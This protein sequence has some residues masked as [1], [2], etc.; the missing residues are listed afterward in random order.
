M[1]PSEILKQ[2]KRIE[3][4]ATYL[5][6]SMFGGEYLSA[7]KGQGLEFSEVRQYAPGD[8]IR[9]ID[10]NVTARTGIPFVKV[11]HEER[12]LSVVFAVDISSS[13]RY[14]TGEKLKSEIAA[15]I[16]AV[17]AFSALKNND[18]IGLLLFS[19][20]VELYIPL[21]KG[22]KHVLR[23][24]R[25]VL[26]F[27]PKKNQTNLRLGL[28]VLHKIL[29]HK[30]VI[31]IISDFYDH[32]YDL[33]LK[34]LARSNDVIAI[35]LYDPSEREIP[36][37]G[38]VT[39]EDA[40]TGTIRHV[41]TASKLIRDETKKKYSLLQDKKNLFFQSQGIDKIDIDVTASYVGPI[42]I[43]FKMREKRK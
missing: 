27:S 24:I 23:I 28:E 33:P 30:A 37:I 5:V 17:L 4:Q 21:R 40:E 15:E 31:F 13:L 26:C 11:F 12:E 29:N 42:R 10:W 22:K 14:G 34:I 19:D 41:N 6:D 3:I 2:I 16:C 36:N 35:N 7:F 20:E 9:T 43:F 38:F 32:G 1:I 18:K 25:D 8:D 39:F